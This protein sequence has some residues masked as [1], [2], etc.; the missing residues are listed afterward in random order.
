M[1]VTPLFINSLS[2]N[3]YDKENEAFLYLGFEFQKILD[4]ISGINEID[5]NINIL[6]NLSDKTR[7]NILSYLI[8]DE[9]FGVNKKVKIVAPKI[10][11]NGSIACGGDIKNA[12][13]TL[14]A[15]CYIS[16]SET[17]DIKV[18]EIVEE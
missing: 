9:L 16:P 18:T 2:A 17:R 3:Y 1:Y 12:E 14:E 8:K 11:L 4:Q 5:V 15:F 13:I 7:F 10:R 6:K